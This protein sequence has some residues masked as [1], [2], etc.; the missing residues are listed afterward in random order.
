[1]IPFLPV[2]ALVHSASLTKDSAT[3]RDMSLV[4]HFIRQM[5]RV[6]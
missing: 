5:E 6:S 4:C 2:I 1:M 3:W